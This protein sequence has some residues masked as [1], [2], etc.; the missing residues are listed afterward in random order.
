[1]SRHVQ[2]SPRLRSLCA[3]TCL[4]GLL[5]TAHASGL[6]LPGLPGLPSLP[7]L[8]L[9]SAPAAPAP[10]KAAAEALA[11]APLASRPADAVQALLQKGTANGQELVTELVALRTL[12]A[13]RRSV[14]AMGAVLGSADS[15]GGGFDARAELFKVGLKAVEEQ[16]KPYVASIGFNALDLHLKLIT[17]DPNLL[18]SE[19]IALPSP[20]SLTP[21]QAQRVINMAALLVATRVT[22]KVLKKAQLDFA[23]VELDYAQLIERR[24]AAAKVLYDVLLKASGGAEVEGL[25]GEDDLRYLRENVAR[26]SVADFSNDLG[27]QNLALRHL[28]KTDPSAWADYKGRSDG[29]TSTTKGY[30]RTTAGI[31]AFAALLANFTQETLAVMRG[32]KG[33]D[34]LLTMPFA[35]EFVKEVPALLAASWA[36]GAAGVVEIPMK[37]TRRFRLVEGGTT[38]EFRSA[39]D[40]FAAVKKRNSEPLLTESL[41]RTGADGLLYK[42]YRCDKSEVGRMLDTAVPVGEREKFATDFAMTET[43][44]FSFANTFNAPRP[45]AK[46]QELGDELLRKDHRERSDQRALGEAQR[47]ASKGYVKWNSDQ[48]LRL[49]LANREGAAALATL[50]LGD[51]LV[52]PVPNMQSVFAYESLVDECAKQFGGGPVAAPPAVAPAPAP[53]VKPPPKKK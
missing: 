48:V 52:R 1:M 16:V 22:G 5:G 49:I 51:V 34:I 21:A 33:A 8:P 4:V 30:I 38:E 2:G 18:S 44:R 14:S 17:D 15:S 6:Q 37:A 20:K 27:A 28:R 9:P 10:V 50:Q 32:K 7:R 12:M 45:S 25:Y 40:L 42:L 19:T 23:N 43:A 31:A 3:A 39:S 41:F 46:E 53:A 47:A 11:D 24:E 35:Y 26:M 36:V 29:L 13:Q